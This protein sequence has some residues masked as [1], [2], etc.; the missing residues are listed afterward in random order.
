MERPPCKILVIEDEPKLSR[1]LRDGL[2][3]EGWSVVVHENGE[4]GFFAALEERPDA[5]VLDVML[6]GK[7]GFDVVSALRRRGEGMPVLLLTAR[8]T[9]DDRVHGLDLGADDYLIKP[10]AFPELVARI[11]ALLRRT[12]TSA[13]MRHEVG[14]LIVDAAHRTVLR[15]GRSIELTAREFDLLHCLCG[16]EGRVV[17]RETIARE[18]WQE[19]RRFEGLD[20]V[21]DVHV[22]RLRKKIDEGHAIKLIQT[23]RSVGFVVREDL[24]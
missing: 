2:A 13:T 10:F 5:I 17:S 22:A 23:V 20:N 6:P 15:A 7:S 9:V 12:R 18:V 21:I 4:S 11:R 24:P 16:H 19:T 3:A 14:D 1:A 8:D